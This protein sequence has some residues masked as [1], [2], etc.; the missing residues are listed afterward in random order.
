MTRTCLRTAALLAALAPFAS[1]ATHLRQVES[2]VKVTAVQASGWSDPRADQ[3]ERALAA[4]QVEKVKADIHFI[5]SDDMAGRDSPSP[6]LRI[7]ARFIRSRLER[8]GFTPGAKNRSYFHEY[9]L[10]QHT[11]DETGSFA[12]LSFGGEEQ[13]LMFGVDYFLSPNATGNRDVSGALVYGGDIAQLT[14]EQLAEMAGKWILTAPG[15]RASR[16]GS[17]TAESAGVLGYVIPADPEA[18]TS[19]AESFARWVQFMRRPSLRAPRGGGMPSI[20]LSDSL[21]ARLM[22]RL[23]DLT[24]G[25]ALNANLQESW[26][27]DAKPV[28]LE[29]VCGLWVGSD[30]KLKN[31][32]I[33]LSAHYDHVGVN[34]AGEIHNGADDNGSGTTGLLAI[35]EALEAYGPMRRSVMLMW[36]SAEEKGLLGSAAWTKD[37]W[38]PEGMQPLCNVNIDMIGRNAPHEL[39]I[40]PTKDRSEY[41]RLTQLVEKHMNAEGFTKLNSA[42]AYWGRSDHANF[43]KNLGI[44]VAFLFSDV[45]EDY[46]KPTDDP[47]KIDYSKLSRVARLVV[48]V[49]HDLQADELRF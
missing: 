19:V 40:T 42:D 44:P 46:H 14:D 43:S 15:A 24:V 49:L 22:G 38:L 16:R 34:A 33:I 9:S 4:I 2:P 28:V 29:N 8:L 47:E 5:A 41:N 32:V 21:S 27:V 12:T 3:L 48:R 36:V 13:R 23:G 7:A 18:E 17:S 37:P 35:A 26:K 45:H 6:G 39:G 1:A 30:A 31:E 11:L 25:Q 20:N 10:T